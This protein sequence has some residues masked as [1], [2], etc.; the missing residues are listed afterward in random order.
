[1]DYQQRYDEIFAG[2][3]DPEKALPLPR[4]IFTIRRC[5]QSR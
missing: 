2:F 1:M 3:E 4:G 5:R